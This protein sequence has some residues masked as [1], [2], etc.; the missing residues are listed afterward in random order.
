MEKNYPQQKK[1]WKITLISVTSRAQHT[2]KRPE[3]KKTLSISIL[4]TY[5]NS[6]FSLFLSLS[7]THSR[8]AIYIVIKDFTLLIATIVNT[9]RY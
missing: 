8:T 6:V 1:I 5:L 7:L 2:F 4:Y 9:V 3:N